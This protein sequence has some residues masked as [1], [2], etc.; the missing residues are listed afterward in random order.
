MA[1][2]SPLRAFGAH[3]VRYPSEGRVDTRRRRRFKE[4]TRSMPKVPG[5]YFF[6]GHNDRLLYVGKAKCLRERVRSYFADT[7]LDRPRKLRRLLAEITRLEWEECGSELEALLVER[8]LIAERQPILNWQHKRFAIYPY[9]L[10]TDEEFPRLTL[11]RAEPLEDGLEDEPGSLDETGAEDA[12]LER[13]AQKWLP[14]TPGHSTTPHTMPLETPPHAGELPGLYLGPFTTPRAA[15]WTKEAVRNLFP[16][17]SCEGAIKPDVDG[18]SCFYHDI[19]R[20][21]GPCVGAIAQEEY[22][23]ICS[24][25]INLLQTGD[26]PQLAALKARMMSLADELRFEDA[27][28][29]KEQM[30]AIEICTARLRRTQ[31]MRSDNNV[32]IVQPGRPADAI[33]EAPATGPK[34]SAFLVQGG[35]VRRHFCVEKW[36]DLKQEIQQLYSTPPPVATYTAKAE[37]DEM[38]ILDRWLQAHGT[39]PCC[40]WMNGQPSRQWASN[41]VRQL[42]S[43]V[44]TEYRA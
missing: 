1:G 41:A 31:R 9:L 6:Y 27:A 40:V 18:R 23:R 5:V 11:T 28:R 20:C 16:L 30:Q 4:L 43:W 38:M 8:R 34:I 17:R 10:L 26:A 29:L 36:P 22:A 37:L 32:V 39:E 3:R 14:P 13:A 33:A 35:V 42:Q 12:I 24:D 2:V 15:F 19:K 44:K 25:L 7:S 21:G